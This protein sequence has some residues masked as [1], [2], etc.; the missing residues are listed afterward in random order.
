MRKARIVSVAFPKGGYRSVEENRRQMVAHLE[1]TADYEPDFVCFTEVAR[2]LGTMND[3]SVWEGEPIPGETTMAVGEAAKAIGTH[4]I[5]GMHERVGG[6]TFNAAALIGRD[7]EVIGRYHKVQ[8]TVNEMDGKAVRPGGKGI[9]FDTDLGKVGMLLCFDLKFPEVAMSLARNQARIAFFP[10]MFNG[11]TRHQSIT[12]D[13]GMFLVVSQGHES[14]IVDMCGR[15]LG[16]QGY[17]EPLVEQGK[18]APFAFAEVNLDCKAYHLDF[19]QGKLGDIQD[20]YGFGI[21]FEI[22]RPEATFVM[23]SLMDNVSVEDIETEF[24][25]EDMWSYYDRSRGVRGERRLPGEHV[26]PLGV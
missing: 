7:G 17:N 6:E 25:L 11:G 12:R 14:V 8:P 21:Q 10:S 18:L 16:W 5:V 15:R 3:D 9:T 22:M 20:K 19:N 13:Y 1:Q 4:A 26:S 2:E 23:S 24:E